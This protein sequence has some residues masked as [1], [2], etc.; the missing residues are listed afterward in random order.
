MADALRKKIDELEEL[1]K[2]KRIER[3]E[4]KAQYELASE[5]LEVIRKTIVQTK[6]L[7]PPILVI[8]SMLDADTK[9]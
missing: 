5:N 2:E 3:D 9:G 1:Y 4:L 7:I 6:D 8:K